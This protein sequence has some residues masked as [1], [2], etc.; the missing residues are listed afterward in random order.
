MTDDEARAA[1]TDDEALRALLEA[2]YRTYH[3]DFRGYA[4]ASI[5]RRAAAALIK[6][7]CAS[8]GE[9]Q[10]KVLSDP[11]AFDELL[12]YLT[13]QVSDMFR[14][15]SF[16]RAFREQVAPVLATYPS[17]RFWI[18]G[19]GTGEEVYS[20]AITLRELGLLERTTI[21]ATDISGSALERARDGIFDAERLP[22]FLANY[23]AAG[24]Q[25]TF[26]T[27]Y[28]AGYGSIRFARG[29]IANTVFSDHSLA[30]DHVFAEV[31]LVSCRNVLIYFDNELQE[32]AAGLFR[33][34]LVRR[35]FLGLGSRESLSF[36]V[37]GQ[38]FD[39][40]VPGERWYRRR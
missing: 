38:D 13:V 12:Q 39:D 27:Y 25:A 34:A 1:E 16:F 11:S 24:G 5:R 33:D 19:C 3:H 21:Y 26:A 4:W 9:L 23:R 29:L 37:A 7:R 31:H 22:T 30:T 10:A 14:D 28:T 40:Y 35:G 18:A 2:V 15:P 32:R 36:R 8:F 17:L 6:L 20:Y